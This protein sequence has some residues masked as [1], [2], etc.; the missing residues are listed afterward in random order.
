MIATKHFRNKMKIFGRKYVITALYLLKFVFF[1]KKQDIIKYVYFL[2][3]HIFFKQL[4]L[5]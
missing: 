1:D 3:I 2:A 4:F 5:A